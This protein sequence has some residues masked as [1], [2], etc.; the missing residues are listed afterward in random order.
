MVPWRLKGQQV[1][2][3]Q[4]PP[5]PL[6]LKSNTYTPALKT[7]ATLVNMI[8]LGFLMTLRGYLEGKNLQA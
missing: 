6:N 1:G 5:K 8:R 3:E 2:L 7:R 4:R